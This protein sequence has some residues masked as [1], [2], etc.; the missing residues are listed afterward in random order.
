MKITGG[1]LKGLSLSYK[2]PGVVRPAMGR[3]RQS[4]FQ[5]MGDITGSPFL[6]LFSGTGIIGM[7]ACSRGAKA[8][9]VEKNPQSVRV[10][11]KFLSSSKMD[12]PIYCMPAERFI[13]ISRKK[14]QFVFCDPPFSYTF[15]QDLLLRILRSHMLLPH[16]V[17][18]MHHPAQEV[19]TIEQTHSTVYFGNSAVDFIES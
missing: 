17:I 8:I 19:F 6:D 18:M 14:F 11:R 1:R 9:M 7:E 13:K 15:K 3:M 10:V 5:R 12:I 2:I 16:A 4:I